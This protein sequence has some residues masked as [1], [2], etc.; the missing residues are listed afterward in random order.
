[1]ITSA[2]GI[3]NGRQ[4][5]FENAEG[6]P[7]DVKITVLANNAKVPF[8]PSGSPG[9]FEQVN[10]ERTPPATPVDATSPTIG[11]IVP[12]PGTAIASTDPLQFDVT[13]N[14]GA[15]R[16]ILIAVVLA[17]VTEL[18]HDG[19]S[20][21]GNYAGGACSRTAISGGFRFVV[22]RDGGWPSSP[23][24]RVFA[25]DQSGNEA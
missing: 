9:G 10:Y 15:F 8:S 16:R 12:A 5:T 13:D 6:W 11:S 21:L 2:G 3:T 23:T 1:V 7:D 18:A 4:V 14:S 25:V 19:N 17:G 20:F 22:L 24:I